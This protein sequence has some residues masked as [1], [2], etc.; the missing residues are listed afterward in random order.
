MKFICEVVVILSFQVVEKLPD[1]FRIEI[2]LHA[3]DVLKEY[4]EEKWLINI[5]ATDTRGQHEVYL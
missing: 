4:N 2:G 1:L 5:L 3:E